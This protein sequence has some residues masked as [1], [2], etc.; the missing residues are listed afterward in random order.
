MSRDRTDR[1]DGSRP[2]V[3]RISDPQA[4]MVPL[5]RLE[6]LLVTLMAHD[7]IAKA[8]AV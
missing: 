8:N 1:S 2:A 3:N 5:D 6:V 4:Y 7:R